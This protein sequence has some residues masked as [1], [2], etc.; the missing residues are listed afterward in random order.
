MT[1]VITNPCTTGHHA[2]EQRFGDTESQEKN[3]KIGD[4]RMTCSTILYN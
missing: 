1:K 3:K 2:I 4:Q